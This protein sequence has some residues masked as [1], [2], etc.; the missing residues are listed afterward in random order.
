MITI[1]KDAYV[2]SCSRTRIFGKYS[3]L[4]SDNKITDIAESGAKGQQKLDKWTEQYSNR[5]DIID[6]SR[7]MIMPPIVNS[8]VKSEGLPIHYLMKKR[9][10]ENTEDDLCTDLI[11]N[12]LYQELPGEEAVNDLFNIYNYSFNRLLKSGVT[13]FNEF[14]LR[15]DINHLQP[16]TSVL[17]QTSQRAGICYPITQDLNTIRDYKYL[18][19]SFYLTQEN[20]LT[21]Y[22]I[23]NISEL[24]SSYISRLYL[25]VA[26][27]K[28]IT[29]KFRL[30]FHK[31]VIA[32]L[33]EYGLLDEST[34]LI[35][36]VYL[37]YDDLKII[38][39]K[40]ASVI[41][42]PR[43]LITFSN[44]YFPID[45]YISHGI[46]FSIGT[47][48][49]GDDIFK[50]VRLFRNR[51]KELNLSSVELLNAITKFPFEHYF[52][53]DSGENCYTI[54]VNKK[55]DLIFID[56]SDLRFMLFPESND[57][58]D[59]C[60][61]LLDNLTTNNISDVMINGIFKVKDKKLIDAD[62]AAIADAIT[63]TRNRLYKSGKYDEIKKRTERKE[64]VEKL[65]M[66]SRSEDEIKLFA[67]DP[68]GKQEP[69][70]K[71]EFRIKS[72]FPVMKQKHV[73]GQRSLFEES[74]QASIIQ[75]DDYKETPELN[76]L[77]T[78]YFDSKQAEE[79]FVQVK[80]VD[81]T[82]LK[83]LGAVEKK[84]EKAKTPVTESKIELPKNVKLRFGDD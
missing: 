74:D 2:F 7:K 26:T 20:L 53:G 3:I 31:S 75:C 52:E 48:W 34:S 50:D 71:D 15:K 70:M 23:S 49:L 73:P 45:D 41:V 43:D 36:P 62:E 29:D 32:L 57:Y 33:D 63:E 37:S 9:H 64:R 47:G 54:E 61:F 69:E 46:R 79:E 4:I 1:L 76:L 19:P 21:V 77:V 59:I 42:C 35:N 16:V 12:Y 66:S 82:I 27:N 68:S 38:T 78:D 56:I 6:C 72:R 24:K 30:T 5:A 25:E 39:S 17:K 83:K 80:A 51:Y 28:D 84:P 81:E 22:D 58:E 65:D 18:N 11:F 60:D 55:A 44:K 8:C 67:E 13:M 14:S 10:Y 40:G